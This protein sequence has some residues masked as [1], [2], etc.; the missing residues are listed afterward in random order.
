MSFR[1]LSFDV[2]CAGLAGL[3]CL[4]GIGASEAQDMRPQS[5]EIVPAR[6]TTINTN[7][8][9]SQPAETKNF[10]DIFPG[11]THPYPSARSTEE[12]PLIPP[13]QSAPSQR[14]KDWLDRR[15]NWVFMTPEDMAPGKTA[16]ETLGLKQYDQN[17]EEKKPTTV[18]ERYFEHLYS[19]DQGAT[20]Q[21]S[22]P[23][24][25]PWNSETNSVID[26]GRNENS[27]RTFASP[28]D[29]RPDPGV[30]QPVRPG[31]FSDTFGV[32]ED[33]NMPSPESIRARQEQQ[34]HME[35][36]KQLW[37]LDQPAPVAAS[38]LPAMGGPA[39]G[40]SSLSGL[41]QVLTAASASANRSSAQAPVSYQ[42]PPTSV[43]TAPPQ[44]DFTAP[45]FH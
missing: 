2:Y 29:T 27:S 23:D 38:S 32:N 43:R 41:P 1:P 21:F 30:F 19:S 14:E 7:I 42:P 12:V 33:A 44:P 35:S 37:N 20:N 13:S 18:M 26:V 9:Q 31:N 24:S 11:G 15:R 5:I 39:S 4:A 6:R 40:S 25:D 22:K 17:G 36:F 34:A 3:I 28:F 10:E 16:E 45:H 8:N